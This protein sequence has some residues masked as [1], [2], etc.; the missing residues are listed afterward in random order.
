MNQQVTDGIDG[1]ASPN[2]EDCVFS[3]NSTNNGQGGGM[4]NQGSEG[5]VSS[6]SF[7]NCEFL[8]NASGGVKGRKLKLIVEDDRYQSAETIKAYQAGC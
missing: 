6:P 1:N 2:F 7:L 8:S 5:G 4:Y 3:N